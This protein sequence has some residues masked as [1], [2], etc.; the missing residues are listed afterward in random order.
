MIPKSKMVLQFAF[1]ATGG[2]VAALENESKLKLQ[3]RALSS[4]SR[5]FVGFE[6]MIKTKYTEDAKIIKQRSQ[7]LSNA[8]SALLKL[9]DTGSSKMTMD[10]IAKID[11]IKEAAYDCAAPVKSLMGRVSKDAFGNRIVS[12]ARN[13]LRRLKQIDGLQAVPSTEV[14]NKM[15]SGT[16]LSYNGRF[17][18]HNL[19]LDEAD[20][21]IYDIPS[22]A[23]KYCNK[24]CV[25]KNP[26]RAYASDESIFINVLASKQIDVSE[27]IRL[28]KGEGLQLKIKKKSQGID[29]TI[30]GSVKLFKK[31]YKTTFKLDDA[32]V[33]MDIKSVKIS[34]NDV[35][36]KFNVTAETSTPLATW[37]NLVY[38]VRGESNTHTATIKS[39]ADTYFTKTYTTTKLRL[40]DTLKRK[41]EATLNLQKGE[42]QLKEMQ[43]QF[44]LASDDLRTK[45]QTYKRFVALK[46]QKQE[47]FDAQLKNNPAL[48]ILIEKDVTKVCNFSK[49]AGKCVSVPQC[50]LCQDPLK[51]DV[52]VLRCE[53]KTNT[54][55]TN[56]Q[57]AY[58]TK[59]Q[60]TKYAFIP[61]Y[62]GS[63]NP[64]PRI[65][66]QQ[67]KQLQRATIATASATG[68]LIGSVVPG[69]G[70]VI[71]G[72]IGAVVGW[73]T[74]LF[75]S[76]DES[77]EV[78]TKKWN[79]MVD[80]TLS[81]TVIVSVKRQTSVCFNEPKEI[82]TGFAKPYKCNC[83]TRGCV[84]KVKDPKCITDNNACQLQR[85]LF[86]KNAKVDQKFVND[87][88]QLTHY[89]AKI[90]TSQ[91]QVYA[92]RR[93]KEFY[94]KELEKAE[95]FA[96]N[97][98]Q[99]SKY[100]NETHDT[101]RRILGHDVCIYDAYNKEKDLKKLLDI[102]NVRFDV[103]LPLFNNIRLDVQVRNIAKKSSLSLPLVYDFGSDNELS[104]KAGAKKIVV[105]TL[106]ESSRR[107]RRSIS[108]NDIDE[109]D[110]TFSAMN[111]L[112]TAT[113]TPAQLSCKT[114]QENIKFLSYSINNL[115]N[116]TRF[117]EFLQKLVKS[118]QSQLNRSLRKNF[119]P[120]TAP[121]TDISALVKAQRETLASINKQI[122]EIG[123][124]VSMKETL[125]QWY[126]N[127]EV[128]TSMNNFT[129]CLNFKDCVD[130]AVS[131]L[132]SI[133][134]LLDV[135]RKT[136]VDTVN[137]LSSQI[138][139]VKKQKD[140]STVY[141]M[142]K[143]MGSNIEKLK[144]MSLHCEKPA[145]ANL[146]EPEKIAKTKGSTVTLSCTATSKLPTTFYWRHNGKIL[147]GKEQ[148]KLSFS[149]NDD[150]VGVYMCEAK[151]LA[152]STNSTET[153]VSMFTPPRFIEDVENVKYYVPSEKDV[154]PYFSCNVTGEPEPKIQWYRKR[155][156]ATTTQLLRGETG[157]V[158]L[159]KQPSLL[160]GG[161]YHCMATNEHGSVNSSVARLDVLDTILAK[162]NFTISFEV[163]NMAGLKIRSFTNLHTMMKKPL[164]DHRF[165]NIG[166]NFKP[167]SRFSQ[168]MTIWVTVAP[169]VSGVATVKSMLISSSKARQ[170]LANSASVLMTEIFNKGS[171]LQ[172]NDGKFVKVDNDTLNYAFHL[173]ICK[174]GYTLRENGIMCGE[175]IILCSI[176][177]KYLSKRL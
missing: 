21:S 143:T 78:V 67:Q 98:R 157:K 33:K 165:V 41:T 51:L 6:N 173:N 114:F 146:E 65:T 87:H 162:Q 140:L 149:I 7:L 79:V 61:I 18:L 30:E 72:A 100:A 99:E 161:F 134:S 142:T 148:N 90:E 88:E 14:I 138:E 111:S 74:G 154:Q 169:E 35:K 116:L 24:D 15:D 103:Q 44:K 172:M 113:A 147:D 170:D 89:Q 68:A 60:L 133:P 66:A 151:T 152:G 93:N 167:I 84:V 92:G 145:P 127:S 101:A 156:T 159:I 19:C 155:L 124:Q 176:C 48:R 118:Q 166:I 139:S 123:D 91:L 47:Q 112:N 115:A 80:C 70:T 13:I 3:T 117:S 125:A 54:I 122:A 37:Q 119:S 104:L 17:C 49:C 160:D 42:T 82:T 31:Y 27:R 109:L 28:E 69:L 130:I 174:V 150:T 77:Y 32:K 126:E 128:Y 75:N 4:V 53:Q 107:R 158:L 58:K 25:D 168:L 81:K 46:R 177:Q 76:C 56:Q 57:K 132:L 121:S 135:S 120:T 106:C 1:D 2:L 73:I 108:T 71:G 85:Q 16:V 34:D 137:L 10:A 175:Y 45:D 50:E 52:E 96:R 163:K 40:D 131:G 64:D 136:Y 23:F 9:F 29:G 59:C 20:V 43:K 12:F 55:K 36:S 22:T 86:L 105:D 153:L 63:C 144:S 83:V 95:N 171:Q 97:K 62:T 26:T 39:Y 164:L 129:S 110:L 11:A 141:Q 94:Q 8:L 5:M 102:E 38:E